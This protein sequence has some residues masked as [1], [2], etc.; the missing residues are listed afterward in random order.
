MTSDESG[1]PVSFDPRCTDA[2]WRLTL[3][4]TATETRYEPIWTK[5]APKPAWVYV[6]GVGVSA[7]VLVVSWPWTMASW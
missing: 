6:L 4:G 5:S 2:S 1:A 3:R 7:V